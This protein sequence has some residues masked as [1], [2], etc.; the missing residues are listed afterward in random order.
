MGN[1]GGSGGDEGDI[2]YEMSTGD[3]G[4]YSS[5][6]VWIGFYTTALTS[7]R[8]YQGGN[9][10]G[11]KKTPELTAAYDAFIAATTQEEQ[12]RAFREYDL[13]LLKQHNQIWGPMAPRYQANQPWVKGF[14]GE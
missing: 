10:T 4:F 2:N 8:E 1:R 13:I 9:N 6:T 11:G 12:M 3:S 7:L 5:P 14:N